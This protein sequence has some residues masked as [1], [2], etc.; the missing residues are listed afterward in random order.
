MGRVS[1]D[2]Q[3]LPCFETAASPPPQHGDLCAGNL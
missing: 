3:A 2:G 1:K